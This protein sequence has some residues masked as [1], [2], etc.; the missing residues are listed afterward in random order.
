M[1]KEKL[2]YAFVI[3][4]LMS[5]SMLVIWSYKPIKNKEIQVSIQFE[6]DSESDYQMF[7]TK[8]SKIDEKS[9]IADNMDIYT[10][11]KANVKKN[12]TFNVPYDSQYVRLDFSETGGN[13]HISD[14]SIS[15]GEVKEEIPL[16]RLT[17]V[18]SY[19]DIDSYFLNDENNIEGVAGKGD[20]YIVWNTQLLEFN[21]IAEKNSAGM[22]KIIHIVLSIIVVLFAIILYK[23][24]L[25][26]GI[27]K[28]LYGNHNLIVDLAKTDFKQKYA[29][30]FLGVVWAFVQPIVTIAIY[31]FVFQVGFKAGETSTGYP[32]LLYLIAGIIPWFFFAEAWMNATNCLIEYNYLVKK[33]VFK[34]SIL[35]IVKVVSSLFVHLFFI[36]LAL[37][38][39]VVNRQIPGLTFFQIIYYLFCT[40]CFVL[41][42]SYFTTAITPFFP[43]TSQI[44]NIIT[45][46]GMWTIPIMYDEGIMGNKIMAI[47]R[48]NPMYYVVTG[49][50]DCYMHGM[51][52]WERPELTIYFWII[53]L[54]L[55]FV[56]FRTF[57]KLEVHFA[58][59]L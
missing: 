53:V 34:I 24:K 37:G 6:S 43:D 44:I 11:D 38:V 8:D 10:Y 39:Y 50:R 42:L 46:L 27:L 23:K 5:L 17:E 1:K 55:F 51:W 28:D 48:L 18:V 59:V 29:A 12:M 57:K 4:I 16:E 13:F 32:F 7:Y 25:I 40:I 41:A 14:L 19:L 30:S 21:K 33:V 20:P 49:Y 2:V 35:P 9:F 31:V 54:L 47:L 26:L 56:G 52:F 36:A 45:Q 22:N 15:C 3:I 58:D